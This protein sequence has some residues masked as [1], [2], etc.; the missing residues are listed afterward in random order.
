M[1]S[2]VALRTRGRCCP[3]FEIGRLCLLHSQVH[4]CSGLCGC[5]RDM[6]RGKADGGDDAKEG[7][8]ARHGYLPR[9]DQGAQSLVE[10]ADALVHGFTVSLTNHLLV[11]RR[12]LRAS[13]ATHTNPLIRV[14]LRF[15]SC[16]SD[17]PQQCCEPPPHER[18]TGRQPRAKL[19]ELLL[20]DLSIT[21]EQP[22]SRGPQ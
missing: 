7:S 17:S 2:L 21:R 14:W 5:G 22:D 4:S 3:L 15:R 20:R 18:H 12:T 13:R 9:V 16:N 11:E 1:P 10:W 8:T 19:L 6:H